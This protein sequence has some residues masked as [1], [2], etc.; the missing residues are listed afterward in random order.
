MVMG[1]YVTSKIK[2]H[3]NI[4]INFS[5]AF[6]EIEADLKTSIRNAAGQAFKEMVK[7]TPVDTGYARSAWSVDLLSDT[8]GAPEKLITSQYFSKFK[9]GEGPYSDTLRNLYGSADDVIQKNLPRIN[10]LGN[11][12]LNGLN[13]TNKAP[14]IGKLEQG[15][16]SQNRYWIRAAARRLAGRIGFAKS[17]GFGAIKGAA[18]GSV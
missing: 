11:K 18:T 10:R 8:S 9:G 13:I 2:G 4:T 15:W 12:N 1:K 6:K 17:G 16:S 14:Y 3:D 7:G 5:D